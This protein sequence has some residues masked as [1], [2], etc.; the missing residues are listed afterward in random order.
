VTTTLFDQLIDRCG[1][2]DVFAPLAMRS[3]LLRAGIEPDEL[4]AAGL[5]AALDE[6][7]A[8][9]RLYLGEAADAHIAKVRALL[10]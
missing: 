7:E 1:I 9:I 3:A 4:D 10:P 2:S 8:S 6:V 5:Q